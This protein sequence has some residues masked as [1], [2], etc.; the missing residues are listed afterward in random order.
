MLLGTVVGTVVPTLKADK[1]GGAKY[2]LI[3]LSDQSGKGRDK[4]HVAL[5]QVGAGVGELVFINQG[6][7]GRNTMRTDDRP[8]DS[9]VLGIVDVI[10]EGGRTV[11]EKR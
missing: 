7:P 1:I 4:F 8:V 5:D 3:E 11:Y 6:S 2:L 9:L 10:E